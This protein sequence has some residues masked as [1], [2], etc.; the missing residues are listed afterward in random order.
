MLKSKLNNEWDK[1][2]EFENVM[3]KYCGSKY[4]VA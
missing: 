2:F 3:S 1:V 4:A